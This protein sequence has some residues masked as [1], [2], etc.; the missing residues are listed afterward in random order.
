MLQIIKKIFN[1]AG[2]K[3]ELLKKAVLTAFVGAIFGALQFAALMIVLDAVIAK[4]YTVAVIFG[5]LGIMLLSIIGRLICM[6]HST[7]AE[8]EVGYFMVAQKR[9]EIGDRLRYIPMGYFNKNSLGYITSITTNTME[10]LADV[11]TRV[12]MMTTQGVLT[13]LIIAIMLLFYDWRIGVVVFVGLLI[14]FMVNSKMQQKSQS[15]SPKKA[16]VDSNLV[17]KVIEYVQGI[18]EVKAYNLTGKTSKK[19]NNSIDENT[20]CN[21]EMEMTFIPFMTIQNAVTKLTGIVMTLL[22]I[23]LYLQG[24]MELIVCITMMIC[25]FMVYSS[26]EQA[27][28]YSA[29]LRTVDVSVDKAQ[30]ILDIPAMDID[31]RDITQKNYDVDIKNVDFS[32]DKKKIIDN[33][34][35]H[36]P[37]KTT[38]AIVGP[39]GGG[40]TTLCHLI[41]RFWDVDKGTVSLGGVNVKEYSMDSLMKNFSF[42]FQDVYLFQDTIAN[43]IRFGQKDAPIEKVI[44]AAKK[45]C[46]HEFI[47]SLPKGY[48]TVI[49]EGGAS[50]SGGEKQ[51]ISIARAIMKDSPVIILDEATAN[52]DPENEKELVEAIDALTRE[53]TIFMIA[54]RLKTVRN[55]DQILVID[56]GKIVQLGKHE[57]LMKEEGI[58]KRFVNS[59]E[60]ASGWKL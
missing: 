33:L 36:I 38:T 2:K 19:L 42:V 45:A 40:K 52:V 48:D 49:G 34:S 22:S 50:L 51:R 20:D 6:Y 31:G 21:I 3:R 18:A 46:C 12:V 30:K 55:A 11:A 29:L 8:T 43:N 16:I 32:Y 7:N 15:V 56:H 35:I 17:E 57:E 28:N 39:S 44:E 10:N 60:I 26:L 23:Y 9:I 47:M 5:A 25:S 27:G 53:K 41:A 4:E 14:F 13:T 24:S 1:F 58:Y 59:R 54:H 37:E